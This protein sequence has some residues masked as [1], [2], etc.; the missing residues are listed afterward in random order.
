MDD[1]HTLVVQ[2]LEY[3]DADRRYININT[4]IYDIEMILFENYQVL[5]LMK[6]LKLYS[7][8]DKGSIVDKYNGIIDDIVY[9]TFL[10]LDDD[11]IK[12]ESYNCSFDEIKSVINKF[13]DLFIV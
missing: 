6:H 5:I 13:I 1:I 12:T 2:L 4:I 7:E 10:K 9:I 3:C 8:K 11:T